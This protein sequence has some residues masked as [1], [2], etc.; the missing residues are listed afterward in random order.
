MW[1]LVSLNQNGLSAW[2][3]TSFVYLDCILSLA[4]WSTRPAQTIPWGPTFLTLTLIESATL[5]GSY[6]ELPLQIQITGISFFEESFRQ[7]LLLEYWMGG[8]SQAL[9]KRVY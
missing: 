6:D 8:A 7:L 3:S 5:L 9:L 4:L 2:V 1:V